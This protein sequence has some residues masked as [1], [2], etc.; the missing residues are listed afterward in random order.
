MTAAVA[1]H[2]C[3]DRREAQFIFE[4]SMYALRICDWIGLATSRM[5]VIFTGTIL[6]K[7]RP[8]GY[9]VAYPSSPPP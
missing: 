3:D 9:P 6:H 5:S 1:H 2:V 4:K 8:G 7:K